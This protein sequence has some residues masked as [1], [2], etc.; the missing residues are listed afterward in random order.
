MNNTKIIAALMNIFY[1]AV[2]DAF[3]GG[4]ELQAA[5]LNEGFELDSIVPSI[6]DDTTLKINFNNDKVVSVV[7]KMDDE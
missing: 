1:D 2:H 3:G 4:S 7:I 5:Y 6:E